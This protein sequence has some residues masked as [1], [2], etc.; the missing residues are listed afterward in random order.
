MNG[1]ARR[2][3]RSIQ[4]QELWT[5]CKTFPISSHYLLELIT[6]VKLSLIRFA[7]FIELLGHLGYA[8]A[9]NGVEFTIGRC[10][11][12]VNSPILPKF[13]VKIHTPLVIH[14]F[15]YKQANAQV[16]GILTALGGMG[17]PII[18]SALTKHIPRDKTGQLLGASALLRS[19]A[20]VIFPALVNL[21]YAATVGTFPQTVFVCLASVF[22]LSAGC[23]CFITP[24]SEYFLF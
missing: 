5:L 19:L 14:A 3:E 7:I 24:H 6:T 11:P 4:V 16:G 23:S 12:F 20:R 15:S 10:E 9:M 18:Q 2:R 1:T 22:L 13:E 21:I 17:S 8:A